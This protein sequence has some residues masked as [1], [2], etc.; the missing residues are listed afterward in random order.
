MMTRR[1]EPPT[2]ILKL[3][4]PAIALACLVLTGC[5]WYRRFGE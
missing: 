5:V 2:V 3:A 4:V 1:Y